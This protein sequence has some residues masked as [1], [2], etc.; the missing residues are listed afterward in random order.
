M[1][2]TSAEDE[3]LIHPR[4]IDIIVGRGGIQHRPGNIWLRQHVEKYKQ[5]YQQIRMKKEKTV[6][7]ESILEGIL[8]SGKKFY[9]KDSSN[10][11]RIVGVEENSRTV[12][13]S[14]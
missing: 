2:S 9:K 10:N 4:D 6:L 5:Q 11:Y 12:T 3:T 13:T 14:Y 1:P 8:A 7:V